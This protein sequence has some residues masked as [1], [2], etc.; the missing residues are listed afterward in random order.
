MNGRNVTSAI[1]FVVNFT[2]YVEILIHIGGHNDSK[3]LTKKD[4][5]EDS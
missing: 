1:L 4:R 5:K 2:Q 3:I